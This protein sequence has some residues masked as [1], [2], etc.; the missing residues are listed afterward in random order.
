MYER[1]TDR[2]RKAMQ[3]ANQEA[4]RCVVPFVG[5]EHILL[6]LLKEG[7]GVAANVLTNFRLDLRSLRRE[8]ERYAQRGPRVFLTGKLPLG[9]RVKRVIEYSIDEARKLDHNYVGTEHILLGLLRDQ[10]GLAARLL[11]NAGIDLEDARQEVLNLLTGAAPGSPAA[12]PP[13]PQWIAAYKRFT[14]RSRRVMEEA[15]READ[16]LCHEFVGTQHILCG[17][18]CEDEGFA[19]RTLKDAGVNLEAVRAAIRSG[20]AP[21]PFMVRVSETP[22]TERAR[23]AIALATEEADKLGEVGV[24]PVHLLLGLLRE[25][26]GVA[27][28]VLA[29]SGIDPVDLAERVRQ[30]LL[31]ESGA[32]QP[33][34]RVD[35]RIAAD[36]RLTALEERYVAAAWPARAFRLLAG[37][38]M[39]AAGGGML[40]GETGLVVGGI[41]GCVVGQIGRFFA[42]AVAGSL[43]GATIGSVH[44]GSDAGALAGSA[45][46]TFLAVLIVGCDPE[47]RRVGKAARRGNRV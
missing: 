42:S 28:M 29:G 10:D 32:H 22:L 33:P 14:N 37:G 11:K 38:A 45:V 31:A 24:A 19:A 7:S 35:P 16:R 26:D 6:G 34:A 9:P 18:L 25:I 1:F 20:V 46:G 5:T 27:A 2:A 3:L 15:K 40:C 47:P 17:V 36:R 13:L 4:H 21:G 12:E 44:L 41:C 23:R 43:L 30:S 8:V 39:G